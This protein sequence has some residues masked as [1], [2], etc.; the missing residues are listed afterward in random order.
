MAST[1]RRQKRSRSPSPLNGVCLVFKCRD[2][3]EIAISYDNLK[4]LREG[5]KVFAALLDGVGGFG[6]S[7]DGTM[8]FQRFGIA[9]SV[10]AKLVMAAR[11][12]LEVETPNFEAVVDAAELVGG[13]SFVDAL[14][15]KRVKRPLDDVERRYEWRTVHFS[16]AGEMLRITEEGF[17]FA[18]YEDNSKLYHF[19]K[20]SVSE[21]VI[22]AASEVVLRGGIASS[23]RG[24]RK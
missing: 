23:F 1:P 19:R 8:I 17:E 20:V 12:T 13:F 6:A 15:K 22:E 5:G 7:V 21:P 3:E 10:V 2:E 11:N 14:K 18:S 16:Y 24:D 9:A 4:L